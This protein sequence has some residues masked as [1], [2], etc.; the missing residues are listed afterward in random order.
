M[1]FLVGAHLPPNLCKVLAQHG[2][3]AIHTFEL[4]SKNATKDSELNQISASEE[5][6]VISKDSD[7]STLTWF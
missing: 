7:F 6:I 3:E 4:P 2:H 1:K 5:R